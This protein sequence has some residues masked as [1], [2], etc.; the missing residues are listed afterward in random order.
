MFAPPQPKIYHIA[1]VDRLSSIVADDFLWCDA[2]IVR[3]ALPGTT[4]GMRSIKQRR[5]TLP[6][7]SHTGLHVGDCVPFYF[8]PR[9][10]MLFLIHRHNPELAYQGGQDPILHFEADLRAAVAWAD[11]QSLRWAFTLSNAGSCFF[12]DRNDLACVDEIDWTAVQS[13]DWRTHKEGKQ[14]EF[15]LEHRFPWH[16]V[17]RI[18]V[19]SAN[20]YGRV[21]NTLPAQGHRPRVEVRPEWYY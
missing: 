1:H 17:E 14:A 21:V 7:G 2:E 19:W 8:C 9:S 16:L 5:L 13:R 11:A 3:R 20:V 4:I 10:V 6:L 15:L 12:E 18:G